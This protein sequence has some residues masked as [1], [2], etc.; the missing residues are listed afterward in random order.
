MI[1]WFFETKK[2]NLIHVPYEKI[3]GVTSDDLSKMIGN[4]LQN[5]LKYRDDRIQAL[6][7]EIDQLR[8]V[9]EDLTKQTSG[10]S[11][12]NIFSSLLSENDVMGQNAV[13]TQKVS[14]LRQKLVDEC[15]RSETCKMELRLKTNALKECNEEFLIKKQKYDEHINDLSSK[16]KLITDRHQEL[17]ST[18]NQDSKLKKHNLEQLQLQLDTVSSERIR[19]TQE[20][21]DTERKCRAKDSLIHDLEFEIQNLKR[22]SES[23]YN[24]STTNRMELIIQKDDYDKLEQELRSTRKRFDD[25]SYELKTK[26]ANNNKLEHEIQTLKKMFDEQIQNA[27]IKETDTDQLHSEIRSLKRLCDE[28]ADMIYKKDCEHCS[29][30]EYLLSEKTKYTMLE[31]E[32]KSLKDQHQSI[33]VELESVKREFLTSKHHYDEKEKIYLDLENRSHLLETKLVETMQLIDSRNKTLFDYEQDIS[34]LKHELTV[35][36]KELNDRQYHIQELEQM[37]IDKSAEAALLSETLETG[38][39]KTQRREKCAEDN[40]S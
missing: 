23:K 32:F 33:T 21:V 20:L 5:E 34:K 24:N 26:D 12:Q 30:R 40:V 36:Y 15:Q 19:L 3:V 11:K 4:P 17:T 28:R 7:T 38:L 39:T 25:V 14:D 27:Q 13:L 2:L 18:L 8:R 31:T 6:Q 16:L 29:C 35:K 10:N 9:Q 37:V 22:I 1:V